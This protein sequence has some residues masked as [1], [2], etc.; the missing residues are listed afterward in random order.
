MNKATSKYID[1]MEGLL[2]YITHNR[3]QVIGGVAAVLL[4]TVGSVGYLYYDSWSQASAHKA[5]IDA[6]RYYEAPVSGGKTVVSDYGIQFATEE[7]K[8]KKVEDVFKQAYNK[9]SGTG[10]ASMFKVHQ[11][12]ALSNLGKIDEAIEML[13]SAIK[14]IPSIEVKDFYTLKLALLKLDSAQQSVQQDGLASLKKIVDDT[15]N[16][17]NEAGLYYLGHYFWTLKDYVQAKNYW[18][19]LMVKYGMKDAKEQ[20][21]YAEVVRGKL[22]LIS[23]DW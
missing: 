16:F 12:D 7:E 14:K 2:R 11:A 4:L 1:L 19:Q 23:A 8:W 10:I 21:G 15:H 3:N 13:S 22:K 6:M 17:A 18:Q 5:F 9:H 20:S